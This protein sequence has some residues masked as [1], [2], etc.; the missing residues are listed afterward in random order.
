MVEASGLTPDLHASVPFVDHLG[1]EVVEV[2]P[3]RC[4]LGATV[5]PELTN[6]WGVA[7]G[8]MLM[9]LLDVAMARAARSP[10]NPEGPPQHGVVT[11]EMKTS[12]M[13][14]GAG[15]LRAHGRRLHQTATLAFCEAEVR[16][17]PGRLVAHATGTFKFQRA[18]P[19][20]TRV[21]RADEATD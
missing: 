21:R 16:D 18:L 2:G 13:R 15:E 9:T 6:R 8:G 3:G 5:R 11:V 7:H 4:T 12:F 17:L 19:V 14:P 20:G 10:I 1:F